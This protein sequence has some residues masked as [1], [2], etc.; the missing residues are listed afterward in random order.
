VIHLSEREDT[1]DRRTKLDLERRDVEKRI[2]RLTDAIETG[3]EAA[4]RQS[5]SRASPS[6]V[7]RD[8][9]TIGP[10]DTFDGDYG[11]LLARAYVT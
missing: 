3:G 2:K 8:S 6:S 11:R 9:K 7:R 10:E 4:V 1:A 5:C